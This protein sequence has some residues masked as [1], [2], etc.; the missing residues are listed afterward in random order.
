ME[1]KEICSRTVVLSNRLYLILAIIS[2]VLAVI[3][4]I[5]NVS[6]R[7]HF[8]SN[9]G[10]NA[11]GIFEGPYWAGWGTL[12]VFGIL[13]VIFFIIF[14]TH[15]RGKIIITLTNKRI[16]TALETKRYHV[17]DSFVL[18]KIISFS[19]IKMIKKNR[20]RISFTTVKKTYVYDYLDDEFYNL[21][22][23]AL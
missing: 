21:F 3:G 11:L 22:L 15:G 5:V 2:T 14:F 8:A 18:N 23:G 17:E 20:I 10:D 7:I 16:K 13:A 4:V 1:E 19:K 6:L 12:I 9:Y